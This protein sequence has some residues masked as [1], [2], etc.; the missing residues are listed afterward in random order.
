[1][2]ELIQPGCDQ[3]RGHRPFFQQRLINSAVVLTDWAQREQCFLLKV[4]NCIGSSEGP[5]FFSRAFNA[6]VA[7]WWNATKSIAPQLTYKVPTGSPSETFTVEG[8][9]VVFADDTLTARAVADSKACTAARI[10]LE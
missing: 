10:S 5:A 7:E 2:D 9:L 1:M 8:G 4:G 6:S 3:A